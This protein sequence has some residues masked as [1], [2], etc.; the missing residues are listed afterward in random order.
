MQYAPAHATKTTNVGSTSLGSSTFRTTE[1][2][3]TTSTGIRRRRM[4]GSEMAVLVQVARPVLP[5]DVKKAQPCRLRPNMREQAIHTSK[6]FNA[7]REQS[8]AEPR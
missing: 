5:D 4:R 6:S 1:L 7:N 2:P 3:T 8:V